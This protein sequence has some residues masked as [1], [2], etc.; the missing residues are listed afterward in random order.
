MKTK[1]SQQ[2]LE[3]ACKGST[4]YRQVLSK[5]GLI[6]AGGNYATI[7]KKIKDFHIDVSH[8]TGKG[9]NKGLNF[10]PN[11]AI[12]LQQILAPNSSFQSN[13]LRNR[14]L[15]EGYFERKCYRCNLAE[16]LN[17][18][19]PLELEH[20]DGDRTNNQ[21]NNLTLLCPNCHALTPSFRRRKPKLGSA[22]PS[23]SVEKGSP[24]LTGSQQ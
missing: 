13:K 12:P 17:K 14:L 8:F 21:I 20:I 7:Q 24:N 2:V 23:T 10:K 16:W 6:E 5:L 3:E 22:L 9:W 1:Y 4:S 15:K 19:I 11:P 18:P